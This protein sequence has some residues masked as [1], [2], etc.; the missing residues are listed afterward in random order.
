MFLKE[1]S[2]Q[3]NKPQFRKIVGLVIEAVKF[4]FSLVMLSLPKH[5][6]VRR[7]SCF[8]FRYA[9]SFDTLRMTDWVGHPRPIGNIC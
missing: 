1:K 5:P 3:K 6:A 8:S 2:Q 4:K 7:I 9:R